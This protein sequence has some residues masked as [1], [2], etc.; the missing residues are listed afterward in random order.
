MNKY[1]VT[2]QINGQIVKTVFYANS[3]THAKLL[4]QWHYGMKSVVS[5]PTLIDEQ[6]GAPQT[7]EQARIKS[8]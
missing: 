8:L 1:L 2:I 6:V 7:P 4:G 3:T 5:T